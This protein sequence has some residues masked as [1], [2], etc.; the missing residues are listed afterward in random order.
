MFSIFEMGCTLFLLAKRTTRVVYSSCTDFVTLFDITIG[1]LLLFS[2]LFMW[3]IYAYC[4][5]VFF[6]RHN[7]VT[8]TFWHALLN[9]A[10]DINKLE[11][12]LLLPSSSSPFTLHN[13]YLNMFD[14]FW[15][16]IFF[17]FFNFIL[18]ILIIMNITIAKKT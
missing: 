17:S 12:G 16:L 13:I 5:Y 15:Q 6:I 11:Q 10:R 14:C 2:S 3:Q 4:A 8:W 9:I 7:L 1:Y 18:N